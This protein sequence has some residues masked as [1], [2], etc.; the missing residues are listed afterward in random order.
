V[1]VKKK[2][3]EGKIETSPEGILLREMLD[4]LV[5]SKPESDFDNFDAA[6]KKCREEEQERAADFV[7]WIE[8]IAQQAHPEPFHLDDE[9]M[10]WA[11][12]VEMQSGAPAEPSPTPCELPT[13]DL[14]ILMTELDAPLELKKE[15]E[16]ERTD[17]NH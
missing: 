2:S 8:D 15:E 6:F 4:V 1:S 11:P 17:N 12:E 13:A 9:G 14:E 5:D 3:Q 7:E 10:E 16:I